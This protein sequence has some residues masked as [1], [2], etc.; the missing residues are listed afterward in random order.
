VALYKE[1]VT[2]T[3]IGKGKKSFN[4]KYTINTEIPVT[5]VL[6]CWIINHQ[7]KGYQSSGKIIVDGSFDVNIWYSYENDSKTNVISKKVEY[8]EVVNIKTTLLE[9]STGDNEVVVRALRQPNCSKIDIVDG[10]IEYTIDK[11][12]GIE[13]VGDSKVKIAIE[14]EEDPWD[15]LID[16]EEIDDTIDKEVSEEF[17]SEDQ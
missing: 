10:N 13:L 15:E 4:T 14:E 16:E 2:K 6:G 9:N 5:T 17:I 1:I 8:K 11:E 12:L 3:V 7:F